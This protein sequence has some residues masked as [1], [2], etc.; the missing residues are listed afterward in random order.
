MWLRRSDG[1]DHPARLRAHAE[2]FG[3]VLDEN[4]IQFVDRTVV[5]IHGT[6]NAL[7]RSID[8]LGAIAGGAPR[9]G[10]GGVFH[11]NECRRAAG[12]GRKP[13]REAGAARE[14]APYVC[15]LDTGVNAAH[16][17]LAP[18]ADADDLHSYKPAWGADDRQGHG[19]PMAGLAIYGDLTELRLRPRPC[20]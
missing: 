14:N 3:L 19:T 5:L 16:P 12:M 7:S 6:A 1:V 10:N 13:G 18:I 9:E 4:S 20:R 8:L 17:L 15:L 2:G 11:A